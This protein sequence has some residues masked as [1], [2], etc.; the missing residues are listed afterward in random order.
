MQIKRFLNKTKTI[1]KA[2]V[3]LFVLILSI[4]IIAPLFPRE[5]HSIVFSVLL[6]LIYMTSV[7]SIKQK[8]S[9]L[10][11]AAIVMIIIQPL[12][13]IF[14]MDFINFIARLFN[15]FFFLFIVFSYVLELSRSK[16]V[17]GKV[18]FEAINIYLLLGIVFAMLINILMSFNPNSFSFPFRESLIN[19][20]SH[21]FYF[22]E[23]IYY[24]FVTFTTL[25]YGEIVPLTPI[26]RSVAILTAITGPI[27]LAVIIAMLVGKFANTK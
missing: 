27:Y 20:N 25:G 24:S 11:I 2:N 10:Y 7:V 26:A 19:G 6:V 18:I 16:R 3:T 9:R 13:N 5:Y 14:N 1:K 12:S 17:D 8:R 4:I 21:I 15:T 22:S 23:Y